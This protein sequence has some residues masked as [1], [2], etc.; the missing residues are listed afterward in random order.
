MS[1]WFEVDSGTP[2]FNIV[3]DPA[4]YEDFMTRSFTDFDVL[5]VAPEN[6]NKGDGWIPT[7]FDFVISY[8]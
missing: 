5:N 4:D 1:R 3:V 7:N 8:F 6:G 2:I